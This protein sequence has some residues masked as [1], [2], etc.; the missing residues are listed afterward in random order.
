MLYFLDAHGRLWDELPFGHEATNTAQ[1]IELYQIRSGILKLR[2]HFDRP[3][4]VAARREG[5]VRINCICFVQ[6]PLEFADILQ[7]AQSQHIDGE[8]SP[9][10]RIAYIRTWRSVARRA[11]RRGQGRPAAR[12]AEQCRGRIEA[13]GAGGAALPAPGVLHGNSAVAE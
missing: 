8:L 3:P 4:G 1:P 2:R 13:A 9:T 10:K 5:P 12:R 6:R 11:P 7:A